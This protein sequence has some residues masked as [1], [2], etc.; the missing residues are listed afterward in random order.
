MP[1][2]E[3]TDITELFLNFQ[4]KEI[5]NCIT[6]P[7]LIEGAKLKALLK[8]QGFGLGDRLGRL[9]RD[10]EITCEALY[11]MYDGPLFMVF[12]ADIED[13]LIGNLTGDHRLGSLFFI[14][15]CM[16]RLLRVPNQKALEMIKAYYIAHRTQSV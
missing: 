13:D 4:S 15:G 3:A 2:P 1:E 12:E 5:P 16:V 14:Q 11:I 7:I 6:Q 8:K 10:T 9:V